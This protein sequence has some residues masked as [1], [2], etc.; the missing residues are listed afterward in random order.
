M[1]SA[2]DAYPDRWRALGVC[3]SAGVMIFLDVSI[4]N[5]AL[6]AFRTGLG[7]SPSDL[8]WI[9][10]G[11]TLTFGLALIPG[12]RLGDARGRRRMFTA[13][14]VLFAV[15]SVA[16]GLAPTATWLVAARLVQGAAGGLLNPQLLGLIQQMFGDRERGRAF[17]LYGAV[18]AT[19][20]AVGPLVGGVLLEIAGPVDGWRWVFLVNLPFALAAL[21]LARRWLPADP[22]RDRASA[23]SLDP[24]GS[25]LLGLAVFAVLLP[26]VLAERDIAAAPWWTVAAGAV[27]LV[28]FVAWERR[29][30]A[31]GHD[32]LV[33]A[34]VL[35]SPGYRLGTA[36]GTLY[37]AGSTA[38]FFVLT[39]YLQQGLGYTA[40]QA[41]LA[42]LPYAVGSAVA[43]AF[44]GRVVGRFGRPLVVAG[45]AV[46]A[47]GLGAVVAVVSVRSDPTTGF[48]AA[49]PLLVAGLGSGF[50]ITP[51]QALTLRNVPTDEGGTAAGMQ[52][53]AQRIGSSLGIAVVASTFFAVLSGSA[54]RYDTAISAGLAA[55]LVF[56]LASF[57]LG[58]SDVVRGRHRGRGAEPEPAR[59]R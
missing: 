34:A 3:M 56:V 23:T 49:G 38:I 13:G 35:R 14:L 33:S 59:R 48:L 58:V 39:V 31:A 30:R 45:S 2:T 11:Y 41:G 25:V 36:V 29:Y 53:T 40:L 5:V 8:S 51:N 24:V 28:A 52:Q 1:S 32:P 12:G 44:G 10:A 42:T 27:L 54:G 37:I 22:P 6:P 50:V 19:S 15:S 43:A 9:V 17:G 7:A 20:T 16:A 55:V 21:A 57:A 18:N 4:V 47:A 26:L 46:M